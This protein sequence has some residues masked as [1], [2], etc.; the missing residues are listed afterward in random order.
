MIN[1]NE[2]I[3][4]LA[5]ICLVSILAFAC[6]KEEK[7]HLPT[8]SSNQVK[9][10]HPEIPE[11]LSTVMVPREND[12]VVNFLQENA[13]Q[14]KNVDLETA[15]YYFVKFK[16]FPSLVGLQIHITKEGASMKDIF[17]VTDMVSKN[18]LAVIREKNGFNDSGN[19]TGRVVFKSINGMEFSNDTINNQ[20]IVNP[21]TKFIINQ[22]GYIDSSDG[23]SIKSNKLWNCT[24]A[25]FSAFYQ[26]AKKT[27]ND[28]YLCDIACTINP[29]A[30]SYLA[31][32]VG[33]CSGII[34]ADNTI[35]LF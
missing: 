18:K 12:L 35:N 6:N 29:C 1:K 5:S 20:V 24:E 17:S 33:K 23:F 3:L 16:N 2:T 21:I 34:A 31:Y 28:D 4:K 10:V 15:T 14:L 26:E 27:C 25:Q 13:T 9:S 11:V 8:L 7:V 30:I 32:A 19:N 22:K